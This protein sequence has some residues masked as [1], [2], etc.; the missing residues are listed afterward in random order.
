M[1]IYKFLDKGDRQMSIGV[2]WARSLLLTGGLLSSLLVVAN[3]A[4]ALEVGE[5]APDFTLQSTNGKKISLSQY[6]GKKL[7]L[8]QFYATDFNPT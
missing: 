1:Q 3:A 4:I 8:I 5:K 6:R 7:V 2:K